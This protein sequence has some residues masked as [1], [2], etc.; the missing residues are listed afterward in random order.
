MAYVLKN[1]GHKPVIYEASDALASGAS[2]NDVGL[3][4]PRFRAQRDDVA[5]FYSDAFYN[6]LSV[7]EKLGEAIDFNP[8]GALHLI[9]DE[10]KRVRFIKMVESWGWC[11]DDMRIVSAK[12]AS[13]ISGVDVLSDC[14]FLKKSGTI[15]PKKI[16]DAYADDVEVRLNAPV[17]DLSALED[18]V[19]ILACGMGCLQFEQAKNIPIYPV[20]GQI[21][22]I[23]PTE[24]SGALRTTLGY[25]GYIAP[26]KGG[27]HC[28]GSSFERYVD[29]SDTYPDDDIANLQKLV[30]VIPSLSAPYEISGNRASVRVAA[31][32][33]APV[34]G[35]LDER[36]FISTA[37]GS[38]GILS[39][40]QSA[41]ILRD[42]IQGG[43]G[44]PY[45]KTFSPA[46]FL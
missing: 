6:A 42:I 44:K 41:T 1:A 46:R 14:L 25:G 39:S 24:V 22:F 21:T 2:G 23:R 3:Y 18:G 30:A 45:I 29:H 7:F 31:H 19:T 16:C 20:R 4:N 17:N 15:S 11:D 8:C 43:R 35:Q 32:D 40:L 34:V 28:V 37:H 38:H 26:V 33:Y 12:E 9:T 27:S 5:E 36:L 13:L 10:K